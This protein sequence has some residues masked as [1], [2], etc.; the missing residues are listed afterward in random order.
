MKHITITPETIEVEGYTQEEAVNA[1]LN[2]YVEVATAVLEAH[3]CSDCT[4]VVL[5]GA[6]VKII[7]DLDHM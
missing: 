2:C 7:N 3:E 1:A 5:H 4:L 6:F